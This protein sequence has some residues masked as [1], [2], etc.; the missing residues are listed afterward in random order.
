MYNHNSVVVHYVRCVYM[1][2]I[3][4]QRISALGRAS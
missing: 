3:I 2:V 4:H 1:H